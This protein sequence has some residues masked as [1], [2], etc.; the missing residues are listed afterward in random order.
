V[1]LPR[2]EPLWQ[3]YK[4]QGLAIVAVDARRD[5]EGA[6]RFIEEKDL[7]YHFLEDLEAQDEKVV[8]RMGVASYPTSYLMNREGKVVFAHYGFNDG[9]ENKIEEE[10]QKLL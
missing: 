10:I 3:K 4:D 5:T 2:L 8:P 6:L 9:D 7:T 1:E